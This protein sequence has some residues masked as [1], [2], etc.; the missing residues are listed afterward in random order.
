MVSK[1]IAP[2]WTDS[3][4]NLVHDLA[5]HYTNTTAAIMTTRAYHDQLRRQTDHNTLPEA[6]VQSL[7]IY[8]NKRGKFAPGLV[9]NIRP[10]IRLLRRNG[11]DLTRDLSHFFFAPNKRSSQMI[12]IALKLR[13]R[14]T[15]HTICSIPRLLAN[16]HGDNQYRDNQCRDNV[17]QTLNSIF[18]ADHNVALSQYT[19]AKLCAA[20][21]PADKLSMIYPGIEIPELPTTGDIQRSRQAFGFGDDEYVVLFAGDYE[22]S[23]AAATVARCASRMLDKQL[24]DQ[25]NMA[26]RNMATRPIRFVFACRTKTDAAVQKKKEI[27]S[28]LLPKHASSV[29]FLGDLSQR[30]PSNDSAAATGILDLLSCVDINVMPTSHLYAKMDLPLVLIESIARGVPIIVANTGSIAEVVA[31]PDAGA[32]I[33]A[34][35]PDALADA[36]IGKRVAAMPDEHQKLN[37][38]QLLEKKMR[39]RQVAIDHFDIRK[40]ARSYETLYDKIMCQP[41]QR[42][43]QKARTAH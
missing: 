4:K 36:L 2:P 15:I 39:I 16:E 27:Q 1:P 10:M 20:G 6:S 41:Q 7:P 43:Q 18:F 34:H 29:T 3:S 23:D 9:Q 40:I 11:H 22:F 30:V 32:T 26:T 38:Q 14:R 24:A 33:A 21:L 17:K 28:M 19:Y 25:S 8:P 42:I 37:S 35:D 12:K 5:R 31:S 13:P